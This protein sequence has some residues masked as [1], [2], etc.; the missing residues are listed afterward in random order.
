MDPVVTT[1]SAT[2]DAIAAP[3]ADEAPLSIAEH[4]QLHDPAQQGDAPP[5][6]TSDRPA[7]PSD[8]QKR[9][10]PT[11][12]FAEGRKRTRGRDADDRIGH[13]A[14]RAKTAEERVA[15]LEAELATA[16]KASAS[17]TAVAS[18]PV[19]DTAARDAGT[20]RPSLPAPTVVADDPRPDAKD[21]TKYPDGHYDPQFFED[22]ADWKA[23]GVYRA[24]QA[25]ADAATRDRQ[26]FEAFSGRINAARTKY[27][28]FDAVAL[29]A[30][31]PLKLNAHGEVTDDAPQS[32]HIIDQWI[33]H[34]PDGPDVLYALQRA[35]A[36]WTRLLSGLGPIELVRELAL[37]GAKET[38]P[39]PAPLASPGQQPG[40]NVRV[41]PPRPPTPVRT[42]ASPARETPPPMDGSL[43]VRD[44]A[45]AFHGRR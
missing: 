32:H 45:K 26:Q 21:A 8:Q 36:E 18:P 10:K 20:S 40:T 34:S 3:A 25:K 37:I 16:R 1:P 15:A 41:M 43:S 4:A 38:A 31:V 29:H 27:A 7:H 12:Q 6:N 28:D 33:K 44:H 17:T 35:P 24:E 22:L 9:D 11:G 30:N 39:P 42:E 19:G 2:P 5:T 14:G 23:R 13:Y